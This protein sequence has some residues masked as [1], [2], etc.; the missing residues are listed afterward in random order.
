ME[1][2]LFSFMMSAN[3]ERGV[4]MREAMRIEESCGS[5]EGSGLSSENQAVTAHAGKVDYS[6]WS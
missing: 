4:E 6:E 3:F 1:P 5:H 2:S